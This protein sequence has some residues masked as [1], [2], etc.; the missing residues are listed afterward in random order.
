[1]NTTNFKPKVPIMF[2]DVESFSTV[3]IKTAGSVKYAM[4]EETELLLAG[5]KLDEKYYV[6][7]FNNPKPAPDWVFDHINNGGKIVAH[8]AL[9]DHCV[10]VSSIL[11]SLKID[12]WIDTMAMSAAAGLPLGLEKAGEALGLDPDKQKLKDGKRLVMKFCVPR[13]PSK[14]NSATR[15]YPQD[16]K[17]DWVK[18]KD[19][20]LRLDIEAMEELYA[21]LPELSDAE[22]SVWVETQKINLAGVPVDV[23][24]AKE[25][26]SKIDKLVDDEGSKFVRITGIF[27][28]QRDKT[29]AWVRNQ[30]VKVGNLQ[31]ATVASLLES[32]KTPQLVKDALTA[33]ANTTHMSFKKYDTILNASMPDGRVRGTL[34]Y[35]VA[36]TGRFGGRLLQT[37]NLAKGNIDGEEAVERIQNGE[38]NVELVKSAVRP[39]IYHPDGF[40]IA[41]YAG[42]EARV[43]QWVAQD[44][45]ALQVFIDGDDPYIRMAMKI[46]NCA[47]DDV[48]DKQRFI[49]KQA[50]LGLGYSMGAKKFMMTVEGY[51]GEITKPEAEQVV[52]IYRATHRKLIQFWKDINTGAIRALSNPNQLI[53][54]NQYVSFINDDA[55]LFMVLPSGR[56]IAYFQPNVEYSEWG[57]PSFTYLSM[58]EKNQFVRTHT[59]GGK[60][61]ENLV[62][63]TARDLL[64]DAV[65][66]LMKNNYEVVTHIHDEI[67]V[68]GHH[69]DSVIESM[70]DTPVWAA[71]LPISVEGE[72]TMRYKK[73]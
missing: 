42:I 29:L 35:H 24:M 28:G 73:I 62:Q 60:L 51:G 21:K 1:M 43:T 48:T 63:G 68:V 6:Y 54:V 72:H 70:M 37:Q 31:A 65:H 44:Q 23:P 59:Y 19:E 13:H 58:N 52:E 9:F 10:L 64:C 67:V 3:D 4:A 49:G 53:R 17:E 55:W 38:F 66:Q 57:A 14:Y 16:F 11:P 27:P 39:M 22:Q 2:C 32:D 7:D 20:Y 45:Q 12:Q 5:F 33:R 47:Y 8:N 30:G 69:L 18:F 26:H 34:M 71:G 56:R 40:T 61:T 15:N 50:I 46:Y 25:I 36:Q 41:D